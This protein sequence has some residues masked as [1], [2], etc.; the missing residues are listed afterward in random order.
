MK[1]VHLDD[2][3][4]TIPA[5]P[6]GDRKAFKVLLRIVHYMDAFML[7]RRQLGVF[8]LPLV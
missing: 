6:E 8:G 5:H 2:W 7:V 1:P 3:K 4:Y